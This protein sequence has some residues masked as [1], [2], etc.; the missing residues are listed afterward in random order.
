MK[1][2]DMTKHEDKGEALSF[3]LFRIK[4]PKQGCEIQKTG[5][6]DVIICLLY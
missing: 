2:D 4:N 1:K 5:V 6:V 3:V